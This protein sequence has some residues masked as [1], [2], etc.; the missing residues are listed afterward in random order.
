[1]PAYSRQTVAEFL[2][3]D[4]A[5]IVGELITA[6][7]AEG[8]ADHRHRQTDAWHR[9]I[10]ILKASLS[11]VVQSD[12][13]FNQWSLLLE[14]PIPRRQR[15]VDAVLL[16]RDVVFV[17]EFKTEEKKHAASTRRQAEDYALDL[18]DFHEQSRDRVIVP[19]AVAPNA[20]S[21]EPRVAENDDL[22]REAYRAN[23]IDLAAMIKRIFDSETQANRQTI[24]PRAWD[25]SNYRPV[26][27]IIEAATAL[28][29]GHN[30]REITHSAAGAINLTAT[31]ER[32]IEIIRDA[33]A[34][35]QKVICFVTGVPGAGKTLAG[36]N[37]V[38]NPDLRGEDIP[39]PV[40]LSG[41]GPL[42]K[43]VSAA[44]TRDRRRRGGSNDASRT[45]STFIQNVHHFVRHAEER[46]NEP[47]HEKVI[48]FDEAQRAW[49]A[50]QSAKKKRGDYSEPTAVLRIM[51]RHRD[52][53]VIIALI[54][55]GQEINSGEAGIEEW[56]R[57]LSA[58]FAHW[59][60]AVSPN[61][62]AGDAS[63]AGHRLFPDAI[64]SRLAI[65]KEPALHL[66]VSIR[67]FRAEKITQWVEAVLNCDAVDAASLA[68][69]MSEF[70]IRLSRSLDAARSWLRDH[71][72]G[73]RRCGLVARFRWH[74]ASGAWNRS[75]IWFPPRQ[76][77]SLHALVSC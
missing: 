48:V 64:D 23:A 36:L 32:L 57:S 65:S 45:V 72:R 46:D 58:E 11:D 24:N 77:R 60:I 10:A 47:P 34:K 18:R 35:S 1:M 14:Y 69:Q 59:R 13:S 9:E 15:R 27:T 4:P 49:N 12:S 20:P 52:W 21:V 62:L 66:N 74:S 40:F 56:G 54:G 68:G 75:F 33:R 37:V 61:S 38:H 3:A 63:L 41:N 30:V 8:F 28:Y 67:S 53:A 6:A 76:P 55:G 51:D 2:A 73:L 5:T 16:A 50:H 7:S 26:P 17:I 22:V 39:S 25:Q 42:V 29:A 43:I 44:I 71:A 70:P 31:S 19:V